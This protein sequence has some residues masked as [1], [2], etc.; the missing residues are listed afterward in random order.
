MYKQ[1]VRVL[2]G[3]P[4]GNLIAADRLAG[5]QGHESGS[6]MGSEFM[7]RKKKGRIAVRDKKLLPDPCEYSL[8]SYFFGTVQ[9]TCQ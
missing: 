1:E 5:L 6:A 4:D 8:E 7:S 9:G 2:E 3:W